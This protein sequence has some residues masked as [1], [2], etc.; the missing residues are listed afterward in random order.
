MKL[1]KRGILTWVL[2]SVVIA[3]WSGIAWR[4]NET[5]SIQKPKKTAG[6]MNSENS[7]EDELPPTPKLDYPDPFDRDFKTA[8][9]THY[10]PINTKKPASIKQI[11]PP[12]K[13]QY[14]G[15]M[16]SKGNGIAIIKRGDLTYHKRLGETLNDWKLI[17]IKKDKLVIKNQSAEVELKRK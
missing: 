13:F 12:P 16:K 2:L 6:T 5:L 3:L 8:K 10:K 1:G 9:R 11:N 17:E 7:Y 15:M 4:M 14:L